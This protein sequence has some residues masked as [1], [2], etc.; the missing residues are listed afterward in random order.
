MKWF[1]K[2]KQTHRQRRPT[3]GHQ[4]ESGGGGATWES[5]INVGC[6]CAQPPSRA[7]LFEA[8]WPVAHQA[9]L[10][11]DFPGRNTGVSCHFLLQGIFLT[12]GS[13]LR[14]LGLLALPGGFFI[15][16]DTWEARN[17]LPIISTYMYYVCVCVCVYICIK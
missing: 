13:N 11:W 16:P 5:E 2:G 1:T 9:P 4:E 15:T 17:I 3:H 14:L 7:P 8:P 10:P 6:V 12:Q